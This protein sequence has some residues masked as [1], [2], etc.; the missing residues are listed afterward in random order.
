MKCSWHNHG[1][2]V[3]QGSHLLLGRLITVI[4]WNYDQAQKNNATMLND[5][6][7]PKLFK[8]LLLVIMKVAKPAAVKL[9]IKVAVPTLVIT[10]QC[11]VLLP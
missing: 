5:E 10:L 3:F 4:N 11:S 9:V 7:I 2:Q 8:I 1:L 6:I